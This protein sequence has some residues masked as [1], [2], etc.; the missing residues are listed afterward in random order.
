MQLR[1]LGLKNG[2]TISGRI[3]PSVLVDTSRATCHVYV[4]KFDMKTQC[5]CDEK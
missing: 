4:S 1:G 2:R 3:L 5:K